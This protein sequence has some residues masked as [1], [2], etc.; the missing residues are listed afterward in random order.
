M[1]VLYIVLAIAGVVLYNF[2]VDRVGE[3]KAI[4]IAGGLDKIYPNFVSTIDVLNDKVEVSI[5]LAEIVGKESTLIWPIHWNLDKKTPHELK[6]IQPMLMF[7]VLIGN[8]S[9]SLR[10]DFKTSVVLGFTTTNGKNIIAY[11][12]KF[13]DNRDLT[14]EEYIVTF[15]RLL[16][17]VLNSGK[18]QEMPEYR[19]IENKVFAHN[20]YK[21]H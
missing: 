17:Q 12:K 6:F 14:V 15:N 13:V 8:I 11:E 5:P 9:Y 16:E 21:K 2:F 18:I 7:G 4:T 19:L 10:R 1:I 3:G 20:R